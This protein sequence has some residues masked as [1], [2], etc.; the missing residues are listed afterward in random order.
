[1]NAQLITHSSTSAICFLVLGLRT[2]LLLRHPTGLGSLY[3]HTTRYTPHL[4]QF[5]YIIILSPRKYH[6][7]YNTTALI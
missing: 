2:H 3:R 4:Q 1:M 7:M 6:A 5:M